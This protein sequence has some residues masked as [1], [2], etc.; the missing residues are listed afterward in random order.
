MK[1]FL[2]DA[3]EFFSW[4]AHKTHYAIRLFCLLRHRIAAV[5]VSEKFNKI[6]QNNMQFV[7]PEH[8]IRGVLEQI[9]KM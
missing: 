1:R 9:T 6:L 5:A 3:G 8:H 2:E 4:P 7:N